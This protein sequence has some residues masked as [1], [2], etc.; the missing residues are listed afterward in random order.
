MAFVVLVSGGL[1]LALPGLVARLSGRM[2]PERWG[3]LCVA[4]LSTGAVLVALSLALIAAPTVLSA[5]GVHTLAAACHRLLGPLAPGGTLVGWAAAGAAV[6]LAGMGARRAVI[7]LRHNRRLEVEPWLG[8]HE[9]WQG[10]DLVILPTDEVLAYSIR[11]TSSQIALSRGLVA[12]LTP[13]EVQAVQRHEA[14]HLQRCHQRLLLLATVLERGVPF[15]RPLHNSTRSLRTSLERWADEASVGADAE[16]RQVLRSALLGVTAA[17]LRPTLPAFSA[18][19]TIIERI[20]ALEV[21]PVR[22]ASLPHAVF[23]AP[24]AAFC[25]AGVTALALRVGDAHFL[26][27]MAGRCP[28]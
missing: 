19:D 24:G 23:G 17:T 14:A 26:I 21:P 8:E 25:L 2:V 16:A 9:D 4:A 20:R 1:L 27:A 12:A 7:A 18:G 6:A 28:V 3:R 13:A 22:R 5:L 10:Y 15:L 11:G